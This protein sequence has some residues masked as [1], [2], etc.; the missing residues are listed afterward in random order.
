MGGDTFGSAPL[1]VARGPA[2]R[3][4]A[5]DTP[6]RMSDRLPP[7][8]RSEVGERVW[9]DRVVP[10]Q[11]RS[12]GRF[13]RG[14]DRRCVAVACGRGCIAQAPYSPVPAIS[15]GQLLRDQLVARAIAPG[16][17]REQCF[18]HFG[19]SERHVG[20]TSSIWAAALTYRT[21]VTGVL[22][23]RINWLCVLSRPLPHAAFV[24]FAAAGSKIF[25]KS[26]IVSPDVRRHPSGYQ[27]Q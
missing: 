19:P 16:G 26:L 14:L 23:V 1:R 17:G 7:I 11:D 20:S 8:D 22:H 10:M 3:S 13:D 24:V 9:C 21:D 5:K 25:C 12:L 18:V 2:E 27:I 6:A 4:G 15:V